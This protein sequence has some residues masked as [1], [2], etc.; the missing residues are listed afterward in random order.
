M[1]LPSQHD[2]LVLRRPD[3][4]HVRLRDDDVMSAVASYTARRFQRAIVMP[5]LVPPILTIAAAEAYRERIK[6]AVDPE[7]RF[8]PLMA[9]MSPFSRDGARATVV[10]SSQQRDAMLAPQCVEPCAASGVEGRW[11]RRHL[12]LVANLQSRR[13]GQG[14]E[15][16]KSAL[17]AAG[18][19]FEILPLDR[20]S[21]LSQQIHRRRH[22]VD[23]V[24]VAGGD[25]TLNAVAQPLI[26]TGLTLLILPTGSANDLA[27]TLRIPSDLSRATELL[28]SGQ[29]REID[30]GIA[31]GHAFFN[32]ASIGLG[33]LV[34]QLVHPKVK[35]LLGSTAYG[36]AALQALMKIR[37]FTARIRGA[38]WD[39]EVKTFQV[40]V[41]NGRYYGGGTPIEARAEIDD[42][43]LDLYSLEA[44]DLLRLLVMAPKI[45]HGQQRLAAQV[46]V[47][48]C[49]RFEVHTRLSHPVSLDGEIVTRTPVI[50]TIRPRAVRVLTPQDLI[51]Q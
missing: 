20:D 39:V 50:F 36:L 14:L 7:L 9:L 49:T 22:A 1:A 12:L 27:R 10:Q 38:G 34:T 28:E 26:D 30:V 8:D 21:K 43:Q 44:S 11:P 25:G 37:P 13:G 35:K 15:A 19:S 31:N 18:Y 3:D 51:R 47:G 48:A 5:N 46:R 29:V 17:E 6:R 4:W 24:A 41:G 32:V 23:A 45:R 33:A 40:S 2:R 16:A 42:G